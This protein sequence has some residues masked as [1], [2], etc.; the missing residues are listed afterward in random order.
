M[1]AK[2]NNGQFREP[3]DPMEAKYGGD[4]TEGNAWQYSWYVP[5]DTSG[6]ISLMGGDQ[7]LIDK[8]D[9]LFK[10]DSSNEK[11]KE[12]EDIEGLIGQYAQGNEP[13]HNTAYL[14][15]YAGVPWKTQM[16][17]YRI[18]NELY[19]NTPAGIPGNEDC[20]QMSAWYIF[21]S[22]GFYPV[23]PGSNQYIFGAPF[24]DEVSIR[25]PGGNR[26]EIISHQR[27]EKN[28][29]IQYDRLNG[30]ILD[31]TWIDHE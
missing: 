21:T 9:H 29:Y 26:F 27:S 24:L 25:L 22:L 2:K 20:G 7:V 12:V 19:N 30:R 14:Y 17:L 8:L 6:L 4:Y 5:H 18:M 10:L 1:R 28:K 3:F 31:R 13:S 11:F 15:V 23:A 16:I